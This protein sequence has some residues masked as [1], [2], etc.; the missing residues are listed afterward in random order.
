MKEKEKDKDK[1]KEKDKDKEKEKD[2][3]KETKKEDM[4]VWRKSMTKLTSLLKRGV[5]VRDRVRDRERDSKDGAETPPLSS[6]G[7]WSMQDAMRALPELFMQALL[8]REHEEKEEKEK[9]KEKKEKKEKDRE[10][11]R[12]EDEAKDQQPHRSSTSPVLLVP[13]ASA[14]LLFIAYTF[15]FFY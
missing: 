3:D 15:F 9:E 5:S 14:L 6:S 1:E 2:K 8:E 12:K 4:K 13:D 7:S 11:E 10:Q